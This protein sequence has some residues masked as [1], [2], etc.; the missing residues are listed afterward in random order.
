LPSHWQS[1][2]VSPSPGPRQRPPQSGRGFSTGCGSGLDR[3]DHCPEEEFPPPA[4][5]PPHGS[6]S[7][8]CGYWS[9]LG[10]KQAVTVTLASHGR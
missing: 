7:S 10:V 9:G 1:R 3:L 2:S 4:S 8:G 5:P 6:S